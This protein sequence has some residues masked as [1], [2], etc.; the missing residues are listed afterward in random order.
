MLK[1]KKDCSHEQV[2][3]GVVAALVEIAY[4]ILIGVFFLIAEVIFPVQPGLMILGIVAFFILLVVSVAVSAVLVLGKPGY[5]FLQKQ[6]AE[7]LTVFCSTIVT[8]FTVFFLI[9]FVSILLV[10]I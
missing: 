9:V 10:A 6:Y 2:A 3:E 1:F 4:I 5:Y 7:A 8:F